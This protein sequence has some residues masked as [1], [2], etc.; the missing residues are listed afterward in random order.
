LTIVFVCYLAVIEHVRDGCT[1][2]A[3]LLPSFQY[4]TLMLSGIKVN[5]ESLDS[6]FLQFIINSFSRSKLVKVLALRL[7]GHRFTLPVTTFNSV[8]LHFILF[9]EFYMFLHLLV[10]IF[11][12]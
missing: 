10:M 12:F 6:S 1:I 8:L 3:F 9:V 4:V 7:F 2:R 11:I 5:H